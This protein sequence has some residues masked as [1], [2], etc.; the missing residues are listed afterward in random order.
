MCTSGFCRLTGPIR[1]DMIVRGS[2]WD[3][4]TYVYEVH[5]EA[6]PNP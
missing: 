6:E 1:D 4:D 3:S 2:G 5:I